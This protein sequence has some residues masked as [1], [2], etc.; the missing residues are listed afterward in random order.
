MIYSYQIILKY[1]FG[2]PVTKVQSKQSLSFIYHA[3]FLKASHDKLFMMFL[4]K[5]LKLFPTPGGVYGCR[6]VKEIL[7]KHVSSW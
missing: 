7:L 2:V 5:P 4:F 6:G 3:T 1:V